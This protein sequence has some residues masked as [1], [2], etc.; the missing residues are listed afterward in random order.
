MT[1]DHHKLFKMV[2]LSSVKNILKTEVVE[3]AF[4]GSYK[5]ALFIPIT[6]NLQHLTV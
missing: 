3:V 1:F 4:P 6:L 5:L 2:S